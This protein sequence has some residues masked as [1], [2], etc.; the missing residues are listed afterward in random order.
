MSIIF[1]S[2]WTCLCDYTQPGGMP[3]LYVL[4]SILMC[5]SWFVVLQYISIKIRKEKPCVNGF[6]Y[7]LNILHSLNF[8]FCIFVPDAASE[9]ENQVSL[10]FS[11][12]WIHSKIPEGQCSVTGTFTALKTDVFYWWALTSFLKNAEADLYEWRHEAC[13]LALSHTHA[14]E[15]CKKMHVCERQST[16]QRTCDGRGLDPGRVYTNSQKGSLSIDI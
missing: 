9:G 11:V 5:S 15:L 10:A 7:L 6:F 4:W 2:S 13:S 16:T 14:H 8:G 1:W 12:H 3:S